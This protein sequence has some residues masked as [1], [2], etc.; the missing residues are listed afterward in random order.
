MADGR[1]VSAG[2]TSYGFG[3][4]TI[5]SYGRINGAYLASGYA[6]QSRVVVHAGQKVKQGPDGRLR[7]HAPDC[8]TGC[9]LHLQV[10]RDGVRVNP[11]H[12]L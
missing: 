3:N 1:V 9:H 8:R 12:Y 2:W 6:H 11:M 7:G 5:I 10:Y 4:Y